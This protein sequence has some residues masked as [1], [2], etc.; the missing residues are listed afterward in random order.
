MNIERKEINSPFQTNHA[1]NK[2]ISLDANTYQSSNMNFSSQ[3]NTGGHHN[4]PNMMQ[5]EN[6]GNDNNF[7]LY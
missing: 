6:D 5:I 3:K 1:Q 2:S 7:F 4:P